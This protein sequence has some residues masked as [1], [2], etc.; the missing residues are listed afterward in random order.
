MHVEAKIGSISEDFSNDAIRVASDIRTSYILAETV[1]VR[2]TKKREKGKSRNL[3][4]TFLLDDSSS[5]SFK[6]VV[7]VSH[8]TWQPKITVVANCRFL[9]GQR[10]KTTKERRRRRRRTNEE[11]REVRVTKF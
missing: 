1:Y 3:E 5:S 11:G 9:Q 6:T 7:M 8:C 2:T 10:K 4:L